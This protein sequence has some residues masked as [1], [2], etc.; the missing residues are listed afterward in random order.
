[1][2]EGRQEQGFFRHGRAFATG[3]QERST[4]SCGKEANS[5]SRKAR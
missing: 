2:F 1:L 5:P 3:C 4:P